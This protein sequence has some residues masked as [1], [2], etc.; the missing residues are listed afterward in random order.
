MIAGDRTQTQGLS[1]VV[2]SPDVADGGGVVQ[3]RR[4][5]VPAPVGW[6]SACWLARVH[7]RP[8]SMRPPLGHECQRVPELGRERRGLLGGDELAFAERQRA[9]PPW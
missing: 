7:R 1:H 9:G 5:G 4:S 6:P 8:P 3:V 2:R